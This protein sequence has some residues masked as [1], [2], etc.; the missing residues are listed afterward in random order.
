MQSMGQLLAVQEV[1]GRA[2]AG[3]LDLAQQQGR[4][5][6]E[7]I[8]AGHQQ[9]LGLE[10]AWA[11]GLG[12]SEVQQPAR[13]VR[14]DSG[15]SIPAGPTTLRDGQK[16]AE[17]AVLKDALKRCDNNRTHTAL[18]LGISR[19]ALYKKLARYGL[20]NFPATE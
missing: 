16:H 7:A 11:A 12:V 17:I 5:H 8:H 19:A 14:A 20:T 15:P 18:E 10:P 1:H 4:C 13:H 3:F 9:V 2:V 6:G